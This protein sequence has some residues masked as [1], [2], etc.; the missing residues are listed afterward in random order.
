MKAGKRIPCVFDN[1]GLCVCACVSES[2]FGRFLARTETACALTTISFLVWWDPAQPRTNSAPSRQPPS[3]CLTAVCDC[4]GSNIQSVFTAPSPPD[5]YKVCNYFTSWA[6]TYCLCA[7]PGLPLCGRCHM[8]D[9]LL[10][11]PC[12]HPG[13]D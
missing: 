3:L 4:T 12:T 10:R 13:S 7:G 8:S 2:L 11:M 1:A 9:V 5:V 6:N